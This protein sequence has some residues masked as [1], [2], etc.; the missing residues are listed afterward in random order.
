GHGF[1]VAVAHPDVS[2]NLFSMLAEEWRNALD[3]RWGVAELHR[4]A[5]E[6]DRTHC[7][8]FSLNY[9]LTMSHLG[10]IQSLVDSVDRSAG[11]AAFV[12]DVLPLVN[13]FR[14]QLLANEISQQEPIL[15]AT[16]ICLEALVF[17]KLRGTD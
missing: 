6:L 1:Q 14:L 15:K 5:E 16:A 13:G 12:E 9:H 3:I 4:K 8:M 7:R 2:K 10:M 17:Q 11:D